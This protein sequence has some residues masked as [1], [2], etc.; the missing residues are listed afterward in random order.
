LPLDEARRRRHGMA[1]ALDYE[2]R[3]A[4]FEAA[5]S[6]RRCARALSS[7]APDDS[8]IVAATKLASA[9]SNIGA[10]LQQLPSGHPMRDRVGAAVTAVENV[11]GYPIDGLDHT[12]DSLA[13]RLLELDPDRDGDNDLGPDDEED[14]PPLTD[15]SLEPLEDKAQLG[16]YLSEG[17][18]LADLNGD[19]EKLV[20][21]AD[22]VRCPECSRLS[23]PESGRCKR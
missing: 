11:T 22:A 14:G 12:I 21:L 19:T 23:S 2:A 20:G 4:T 6:V 13:N 10:A 17:T 18:T 3:D 8:P 5:D 9:S 7:L 16:E 15:A 1:L